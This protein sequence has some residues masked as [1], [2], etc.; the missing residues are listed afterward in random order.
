MPAVE[1]RDLTVEFGQTGYVVRPLDRLSF[2]A[3]EGELVAV[4]G[5]SGSGKTTLLSCL[6]GIL[7]PTSGAVAVDGMVVSDRRGAALDQ[8]RRHGVGIVFRAST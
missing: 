4:L 2:D 1:V 8:Y 5:P 6:A 7:S 3:A